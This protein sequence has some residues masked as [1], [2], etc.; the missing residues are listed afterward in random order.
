MCCLFVILKEKNSRNISCLPTRLNY[1]L[2]ND[3]SSDIQVQ[4]LSTCEF[5]GKIPIQKYLVIFIYVP[6]LAFRKW[7]ATWN[8]QM[9]DKLHTLCRVCSVIS[10]LLVILQEN[11]NRKYMNVV[12]VAYSA[13]KRQ[14]DDLPSHHFEGEPQ[15]RLH[16][17]CLSQL[18]DRIR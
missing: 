2:L 5:E 3:N 12:K 17:R 13:V 16:Q 11:L 4:K 15:N 8:T 6:D 7:I 1:Y 9:F 18:I 14:F 10:C